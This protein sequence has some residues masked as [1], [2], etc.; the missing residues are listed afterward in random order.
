MMRCSDSFLQARLKAWRGANSRATDSSSPLSRRA[1]TRLRCWMATPEQLQ[2]MISPSRVVPGATAR[3]PLT[4]RVR[5]VM[6]CTPFSEHGLKEKRDRPGDRRTRGGIARTLVKRVGGSGSDGQDTLDGGFTDREG[7]HLWA[8]TSADGETAGCV[9]ESRLLLRTTEYRRSTRCARLL[10]F[11]HRSLLLLCASF[12]LINP[13]RRQEFACFV[14]VAPSLL[15]PLQPARPGPPHHFR[16]I[17]TQRPPQQPR[18]TPAHRGDRHC[19]RVFFSP[20]VPPAS[21]TTSLPTTTPGGD[22]TPATSALGSPPVPLH[23]WLAAGSP[24]SDAPL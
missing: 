2:V 20:A 21:G 11:A 12:P 23:S 8:A 10:A 22:A 19:W 9:L 15:I 14:V 4:G 6:D 18:Q 16:S 5:V 13:L 3:M 17:T 7:G 24:R 1:V